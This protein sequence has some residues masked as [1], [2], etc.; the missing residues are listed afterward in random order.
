MFWLVCPWLGL[1][2][3]N[4]GHLLRK[5]GSKGLGVM[6]KQNQQEGVL[7][8][9]R[10]TDVWALFIGVALSFCWLVTSGCWLGQPGTGAFPVPRRAPGS[11]PAISR[12]FCLILASFLSGRGCQAR[13]RGAK[14]AGS[15]LQSAEAAGGPLVGSEPEPPEARRPGF[16]EAGPGEPGGGG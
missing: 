1:P 15:R 4:Q 16:R 14:G 11:E 9:A 5:S 8:C 10:A 2:G 7:L 12:F 6:P 13:T 3:R